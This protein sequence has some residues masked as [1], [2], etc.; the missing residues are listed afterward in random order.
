[1]LYE[2]LVV[3]LDLQDDVVVTCQV[4]ID[5]QD[6]HIDSEDIDERLE[7]VLNGLA[8]LDVDEVVC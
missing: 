8:I 3:G 1:M 7:D 2:A 5:E 6:V 4:Q